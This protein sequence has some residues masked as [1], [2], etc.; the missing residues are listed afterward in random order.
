MVRRRSATA[1]GAVCIHNESED[2]YPRTAVEI[3][4]MTRNY[5]NSMKIAKLEPILPAVARSYKDG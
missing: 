1:I 3:D 5:K 2:E 4:E